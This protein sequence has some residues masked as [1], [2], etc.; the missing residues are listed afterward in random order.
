M[1]TLGLKHWYWC[2]A[3]GWM[4]RQTNHE[5]M[6]ERCP[7]CLTPATGITGLNGELSYA[8]AIAGSSAGPTTETSLV[9]AVF[10]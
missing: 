3:C 7:K 8:A 2:E 10:S 6:P 4:D 9:A 5:K 1:P